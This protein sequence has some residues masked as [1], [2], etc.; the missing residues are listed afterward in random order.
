[1]VSVTLLLVVMGILGLV[2]LSAHRQLSTSA[3][4]MYI[5]IKPA[6]A[7]YDIAPVKQRLNKAPYATSYIFVTADQILAMETND[8]NREALDLLGENPFTDEFEVTL[9]NAWLNAD[10]LAKIK[11]DLTQLSVVDEVITP[12]PDIAESVSANISRIIVTTLAFALILLII[13]IALINNTVSLSIYSRRFVIHT[14]KLIGATH[15]Y[16]R[17][18]FVRAGAW[19][20]LISGLIATAILSGIYAWLDATMPDMTANLTWQDI[21]IA[22]LVLTTLAMAVCAL[23][24]RC[25]ATRYLN[26]NYDKL[27]MK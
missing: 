26:K 25:A 1:M 16:I 8:D 5:H 11:A 27:F 19:A 13:S 18:P 22:G 6:T 3:M 4:S 7:Q 12:A 20:G 10:S 23:T 2:V 21:I 15:S 9:D 24:A 14:M 17:R